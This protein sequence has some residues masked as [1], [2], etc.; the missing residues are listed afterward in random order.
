M[1]GL[2][3]HIENGQQPV[4]RAAAQEGEGEDGLVSMVGIALERQLTDPYV[5]QAKAEGYRSRAAYKLIELVGVSNEST[6]DAIRG[7]IARAAE[8]LKAIDWF[9][10]TE[11]RGLVQAG[12][13]KQFQVKLKVGFRLMA[14]DELRAS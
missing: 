3:L 6:E 5:K 4:E 2:Q 8:T 14:E 9:E 12:E 1:S 7:A 11:I 10:V 13:V